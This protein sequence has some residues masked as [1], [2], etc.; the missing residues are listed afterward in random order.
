MQDVIGG[1]LPAE[2]WLDL[3]KT[4]HGSQSLSHLQPCKVYKIWVFPKIGV[5]PPK[6]SILIGSSIINHPFSGYP[7]FWKH[8]Y[9]M[10]EYSELNFEV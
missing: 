3:Q 10:L 8:P 4:N 5:G 9:R 2:P 1:K 6:L 7:Y